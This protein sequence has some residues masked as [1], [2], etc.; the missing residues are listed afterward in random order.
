[1]KRFFL[2]FAAMLMAFS[3]SAAELN[4]YASGLKAGEVKDGKV[5]ISYLLNATA[6]ALEVQLIGADNA[7]AKAFPLTGDDLAKGAHKVTVDL[8]DVA[9]GTYTWAV[10]ASAAATEALV[11]ATPEATGLY[12]YYLPQG[13]AVNI[14]PESAYFG[15]IYVGEGT[16][17]DTDGGTDRAK[18]MTEGIYIYNPLLE[19]YSNQGLVGYAGGVQWAAD[20]QGP[21]R[22]QV[23]EDGTL[24]IADNGAETS[25]VWMMDPANPSADF[26]AALDVA[27]RGTNFVKVAAIDVVGAGADRVLYTLDNISTGGGTANAYA[28]GECATPFAGAPTSIFDPLSVTVGNQDCAIAA[29]GR[30][31]FWVCQNRW[32]DDTYKAL[33]HVNAAGVADFKSNA[34][35]LP[36]TANISY[37]G[38]VTLNADKTLLA[39]G[40]NKSAV[41]FAIAYDA[42][43][44]AP[45]L[46]ELYRTAQIGG[47]IDGVAFDYAGNLYVLSASTERLYAFATPKADNTAI[48]PAPKANTITVAAAEVVEL[49]ETLYL[50]PNKNW[51]QPGHETQPR[52]AA[53]YFE[54]S[55]NTWVDMTLVEGETNV[56]SVAVPEGYT[57][58]IFCRMNGTTTENNWDNKYN[59]TVDLVIPSDGTNH[60][61]VTEDTWDKG[62]GVWSVYTPAEKPAGTKYVK[63]T[64]APADWTGT[65][66]LAY[67]VS[68][69]EAN[70]FNGLDAEANHVAATIANGAIE[71]EGLVELEIAAVEGGYS[72]QLVG[73]EKDG[74]FL[75]HT[76]FTNK[77]TF[78]DA[79]IVNTL[80]VEETGIKIACTVDN[81]GTA[82]E[83]TMRFNNATNNGNRFRYYKSGQQPVQLYKKAEPIQEPVQIRV[84]PMFGE[85]TVGD[86]FEVTAKFFNADSD[87][88]ELTEEQLENLTWTATTMDM[89]TGDD[90]PYEG[91]QLMGAVGGNPVTVWLGEGTQGGQLKVTATY[92]DLEPAAGWFTILDAGPQGI[93]FT[94]YE[95]EIESGATLQL[96][97][98]IFPE[99]GDYK[100]IWTSEDETLATVSETGLVTSLYTATDIDTVV[101][102]CCSIEGYEHKACGEFTLLAAEAP[103]G[104]VYDLDGG[105]VLPANNEELY[106]LL[107]AYYPNFAQKGRSDQ[108]IENAA[109]FFNANTDKM[110]TDE[111]SAY[112]WLGDYLLPYAEASGKTPLDNA[113]WRWGLRAF[114]EASNGVYTG[115]YT[116]F[117]CT[118]AGKPENWQAACADVV[119]NL[120]TSTADLGYGYTWDFLL[121][122]VVKEGYDFK[123]WKDAAG[124]VVT[125][126][127]ANTEAGTYTAQWEAKQGTGLEN[128][129]AEQVNV[130]KVFEN[131]NVYILRDGVKYTITGI[132]VE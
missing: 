87:P 55:A 47:N 23:A 71:S 88:I 124:N 74:K 15:Y 99:G 118:E 13:L 85:Y 123:G 65:Y 67:E 34:T 69:T 30:G 26:K 114:L 77:I 113:G 109:T 95:G 63:V 106:A 21:K 19:D 120:P 49:P 61:T 90:I 94:P 5:E 51:N 110:M 115:K 17:G 56:Y 105:K 103:A 80:S 117:D 92:G 32:G 100:V 83:V 78:A 68:E 121:P 31:G 125:S 1:M 128:A 4:I 111:T 11:D 59:Q 2:A 35:L 126:I 8:A 101:T 108:T 97:A 10:K 75:G 81:K 53:Y 18:T 98:E 48:T 116:S 129:G 86:M 28:I 93:N 60:Y 27:G 24:F 72:I 130:R 102:I 43:T 45:T 84:D 54:G 66:I 112:K 122:S 52:F 58:V 46:T 104:I 36:F 62:G 14:Y 6:T 76:A 119:F 127:P 44:G 9:A 131:G 33:I 29:D 73:G 39:M 107:K 79:A 22:I 42:E 38:V 41:V 12:D 132:V 16:P 7:V 25:G 3:V 89:E 20:R 40:S 64:E 82:A 57:N 70:V 91:V 96:K 37:R 50:T